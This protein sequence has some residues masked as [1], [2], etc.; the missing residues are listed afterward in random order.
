MSANCRRQYNFTDIFSTTAK[1]S[2]SKMSLQILMAV[3]IPKWQLAQFAQLQGHIAW[4]PGM[5]LPTQDSWPC[6]ACLS[7]N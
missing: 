1:A 7:I 2:M 3:R 4:C 5:D 6:P